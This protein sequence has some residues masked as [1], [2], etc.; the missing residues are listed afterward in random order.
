MYAEWRFFIAY[1]DMLEMVLSKTDPVIAEF[2]ESR[3]VTDELRVLGSS[4]RQRL[5]TTMDRVLQ[6]KQ[7]RQVRSSTPVLRHS[8]DGRNPDLDPRHFL[9]AELLHRD[10]N[11]PTERLEQALMVTM[12]GISAGMQNTG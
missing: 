2:Y 3:L 1:I 6:I 9:Q 8:I 7:S 10:R 12:T 5:H 4:L 11:Q